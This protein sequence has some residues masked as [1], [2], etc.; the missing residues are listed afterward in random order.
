MEMKKEYK[1]LTIPHITWNKKELT[2]NYGELV[3]QPLEPG[4]GITLGNALR[5]ILLGGIEGSAVTAV[6]IKGVNNEFTSLPG[7]VEDAMQVLLNIKEIVIHNK[8]GKPGTMR[9][10]VKGEGVLTVGDIECDEHLTTINKDHVIAHVA[11]G[12]EL[13]IEFFV[14]SGRGYVS[15]QWPEGKPLQEDGKIYLDA[16]F[17][18]VSNVTFDVEKTRVGKD[19]D[20]DKLILRISTDG[21]EDPVAVTHY[22]VSVLR[23]QFEHFLAQAEIPFNEISKPA[24]AEVVSQEDSATAQRLKG[25]ST[26]VLLKPIAALELSVRAHNCL[27]AAGIKRIIDL[28]RLTEDELVKVKN[29]GRKSLSEV[30]DGLKMFGL[31]LGMEISEEDLKHLLKMSEES[32]TEES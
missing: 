18:P 22:S 10:H 6:I 13:D 7:V 2:N 12:G 5:R 23:S 31:D 8:D 4:F 29:F 15:A 9:A 32:L 19:I 14:E 24:V 3:A 30:R 27:V 28:A 17:S 26:E 11:P 20:Y 1:P 16:M 25:I 21:S